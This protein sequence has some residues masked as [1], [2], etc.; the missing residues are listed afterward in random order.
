MQ[1]AGDWQ[2]FSLTIDGRKQVLHRDYS[3]YQSGHNVYI[4]FR[5]SINRSGRFQKILFQYDN[6][7]EPILENVHILK[8]KFQPFGFIKKILT[9]FRILPGEWYI[10]DEQAYDWGTIIT[11]G[12]EGNSASYKL[13]GWSN[14]EADYTWSEGHFALLG[15]K[16][17][18]VRANLKLHLDAAGLPSP[19]PQ[20]VQVRV[21]RKPLELIALSVDRR[22]YD[23]DIP[24]EYLR[25]DGIL[26]IEFKFLNAMSPLKLGINEDNR[27]LA[28]AMYKLLL[29]IK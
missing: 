23:I 7:D 18:P 10:S 6:T 13:T 12:V 24:K 19:M 1:A 5:N 28:M 11:M 22:T 16:T 21:N 3:L 26:L 15:L 25:E 27:I 17:P 9:Q 2:D 14:E 4:S 29:D 8:K 20:K